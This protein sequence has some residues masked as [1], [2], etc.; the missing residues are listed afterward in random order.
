MKLRHESRKPQ[1]QSACHV[2]PQRTKVVS[3]TGFG[4]TFLGV[5]TQLSPYLLLGFFVA[6][7]LHA[8]VPQSLLARALGGKGMGAIFRGA[9]IGVPLPL[10]SCSVIPVATTLRDRG[11]GR[12]ATASFLVS[13]PETGVDSISASAAM[14]HPLMVVARPL[15]AFCTGIATGFAVERFSQPPPPTTAPSSCH[16]SADEIEQA[17]R[18]ILG[19]MRYAFVDMF[20][21]LGIW[22]LPALLVTALL[23]TVFD[24]GDVASAFSSQWLQMLILLALGI[25]LYVCATA[26]TPVA[27]ALITAGFSPGSAL[28]FLLV[29][30]ATNLATIGAAIRILGKKGAFIYC[31]II[32]LLS[33]G[34]GL[35]LDAICRGFEFRPSAMAVPHNAHAGLIEWMSTSAI[36]ILVCWH[37]VRWAYKRLR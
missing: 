22:L 11:A 23:T 36:L 8:F 29:G 12:G 18:G 14:L 24:P 2:H 9:A 32:V 4:E 30:P 5:L 35:I 15:A 6:G 28:V 16:E 33:I 17:P 37:L 19:G 20:A 26:A 21:E 1:E 27:A 34:F 31:T 10:C 7:L 13:S 25:P 3:M